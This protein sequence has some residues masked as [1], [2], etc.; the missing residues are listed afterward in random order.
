MSMGKKTTPSN[1]TL[2]NFSSDA[3][4]LAFE[5]TETSSSLFQSIGFVR[6]IPNCNNGRSIALRYY[7]S[8]AQKM[9]VI[10]VLVIGGTLLFLV[11]GVSCYFK[12]QRG[13][14]AKIGAEN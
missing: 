1:N 11:T 2:F 4:L 12:T 14:K 5:G 8:E 10:V 13:R 6:V 7:A 3:Q 9:T